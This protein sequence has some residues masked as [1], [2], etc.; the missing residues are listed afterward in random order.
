MYLCPFIEKGVSIKAFPLQ[1]V[2]TT[3]LKLSSKF[4]K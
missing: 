4:R 3:N 1:P 2:K